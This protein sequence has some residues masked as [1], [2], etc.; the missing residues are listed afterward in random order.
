M[1][2]EN[3]ITIFNK[4]RHKYISWARWMQV[5]LYATHAALPDLNSAVKGHK[6]SFTFYN[7]TVNSENRNSLA[8]VLG[9]YF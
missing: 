7:F 3:F 9:D 1:E 8:S 5:M 4:A 2:R 6:T